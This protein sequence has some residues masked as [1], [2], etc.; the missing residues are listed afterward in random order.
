[1]KNILIY[2]F[3]LIAITTTAFAQKDAQAKAIL[4]PLSQKYKAYTAIKS[5]FTFT[6]DDAQENMKA[7]QNGSLI[8]QPKANKFRITLYAQN[9][10]KHDVEQEIISDGKSQWTYNKKDKEVQQNNAD[11]NSDGFNPAQIFT[12][13][14]HGYKY[15][16]TGDQKIGGKVYQVIDLSPENDK[17]L[18]FKIRL[19]IDKVKKQIYSTLIFDKNGSKYNYVFKTFVTNPPVTDDTFTFDPKTHPGVEV[20]DLR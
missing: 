11:H 19:M 2:T 16:Y 9:S 7:T 10:A 20:V 4:D 15:L 13:Y 14:E 5:D 12:V 17:N 6:L 1:M 3:L 8:V 18:Y